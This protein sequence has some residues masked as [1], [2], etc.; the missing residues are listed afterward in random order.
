[1]TEDRASRA[2]VQRIRRVFAHAHP[3][4]S[5]DESAALIGVSEAEIQRQLDDGSVT[6]LRFGGEVR[7]AW[8]DLVWLGL[9]YRWT[10][11]LVSDAVR[12][13]RAAGLLPRLVRVIPGTL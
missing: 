10:Y 11:R 13:R 2:D 3:S 8:S 7:I 1:M 12:G 9:A 4:Y 5:V 6:A